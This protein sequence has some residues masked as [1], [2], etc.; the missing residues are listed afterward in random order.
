MRDDMRAFRVA[1]VR[2]IEVATF[3]VE[4]EI[5]EIKGVSQDGMYHL[6]LLS[7]E[8][9]WTTTENMWFILGWK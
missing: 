2:V 5:K 8:N 3:V 7:G 4:E 6:Q 1:G 9:V